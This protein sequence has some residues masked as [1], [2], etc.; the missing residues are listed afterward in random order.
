MRCATRLAS[1]RDRY[2]SHSAATAS[3]CRVSCAGFSLAASAGVVLI[4]WVCFLVDYPITRDVYFT[5][6]T[7][8]VLAEVPFLLRML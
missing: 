5:V 2:R 4:L 8:H 1:A 3:P 7:V 6:A